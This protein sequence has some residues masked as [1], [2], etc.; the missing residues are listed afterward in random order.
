MSQSRIE[1]SIHP[2]WMGGGGRNGGRRSVGRKVRLFVQQAQWHVG[3]AEEKMEAD[4]GCVQRLC[5]ARAG[6]KERKG[7]RVDA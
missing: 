2:A 7:M 5:V 4:G 6:R 3:L 1:G